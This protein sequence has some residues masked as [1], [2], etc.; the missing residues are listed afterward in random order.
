MFN[1]FIENGLDHRYTVKSSINASDLA[2]F[3]SQTSQSYDLFATMSS[4]SSNEN[5]DE[6]LLFIQLESGKTELVSGVGKR[7]SI[8]SIEAQR[9]EFSHYLITPGSTS[10]FVING[11]TRTVNCQVGGSPLHNVSNIMWL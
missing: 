9:G 6:Q 3:P 5:N 1:D 8:S 2:F 7:S 11:K 10:A 4:K